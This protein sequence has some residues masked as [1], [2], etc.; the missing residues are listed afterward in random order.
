VEHLAKQEDHVGPRNYWQTP[1]DGG[2]RVGGWQGRLGVCL[3]GGPA[4]SDGGKW[5]S[6]RGVVPA[7]VRHVGWER[8]EMRIFSCTI[9]DKAGP[10]GMGG[11]V[12]ILL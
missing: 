3:L 8:E 7:A 10:L 2:T 5:Q 6:R 1:P 4:I 9:A 11:G 12:E